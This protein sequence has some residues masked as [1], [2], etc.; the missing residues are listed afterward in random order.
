MSW[1]PLLPPLSIG[2]VIPAQHRDL[3]SGGGVGVLLEQAED[4]GVAHTVSRVLTTEP[5]RNVLSK[6]ERAAVRKAQEAAVRHD[7]VWE[8]A[9]TRALSA[10][11][12]GDRP[13]LLKGAGARTLL[14]EHP[15]DRSCVDLDIMLP[16]GSEALSRAALEAAGWEDEV[17]RRSPLWHV[18][19]MS[20]TTPLATM[21]LEIHRTLDNSERGSIDYEAL[22]PSCL[23]MEVM[24]R[25]CLVPDP[26]AQLL[27]GA[28][29]ALRHGLEVPLKSLIDIH[30]AA[31]ACDSDESSIDVVRQAPGAAASL[32]VMLRLCQSLFG[33]PV[34][35]AWRKA[36]AP[37]TLALPLL[38]LTLNPDVAG[39]AR[40]PLSRSTYLRRFW[41]QALITGSPLL[42][43]RV[44][45]AWLHRRLGQ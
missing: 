7:M 31:A 3:D 34:P 32:G 1:H 20:I 2:A 4:Q 22:A 13:I 5:W 26:A 44:A 35:T 12:G 45:Y 11:P 6:T 28:T 16:P 18:H 24:G 43:C 25:P 30:L 36:L 38:A 23:E 17:G 42:M 9:A 21:S 39:Y 29:H 33:T 14:Y 40:Q 27:V 15:G 10:L 19:G 41:F 8:Q 37:P